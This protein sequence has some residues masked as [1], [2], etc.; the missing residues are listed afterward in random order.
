MPSRFYCLTSRPVPD[1]PRVGS[2][3]FPD[4][5]CFHLLFQQDGCVAERYFFLQALR[6]HALLFLKLKRVNRERVRFE[7]LPLPQGYD[8][9]ESGVHCQPIFHHMSARQNPEASLRLFL[10]GPWILDKAPCGFPNFVLLPLANL[11]HFPVLREKHNAD[12]RRWYS[13]KAAIQPAQGVLP[14]AVLPE[15]FRPKVDKAF[16]ATE[17]IP[18]SVPEDIHA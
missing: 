15:L 5:N 1:I 16:L 9:A 8:T 10:S 14:F 13:R 11:W 12:L 18:C 3:L 4:K 2:R 7:S 6:F 17:I